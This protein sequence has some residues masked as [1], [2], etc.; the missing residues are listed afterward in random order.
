PSGIVLLIGTNDLEEQ[1]DP[2]VIVSNLKLILAKLK[3]SDSKMPI[4]VCQVFPSS[5]TKKR[6]ADQIKKVNQLIAAAVK[7]DARITLL[8]TWPLFA[9]A[10]GDAKPE[11]F[12]DLLH[13]NDAGYR[14]WAAA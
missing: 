4:I 13:L 6:P 9:N 10:E 3:E 5:A 12:Y 14:K 2:E 7:G 11:E 8:E 1:A